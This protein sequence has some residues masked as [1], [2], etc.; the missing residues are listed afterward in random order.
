MFTD[1][2]RAL[3]HSLEAELPDAIALREILHA[4]PEPSHGEGATAGLVAEALGAKS[5]TRVAGTGLMA[6]AGP[7]GGR[8]VAV[9]AELDA[10][11]IKEATGAPFAATNGLMHACGHDVHMAALV[12]LF[13]AARRVE[14]RLPRPVLALYQPSEE[15][16]PSGAEVVAREGALADAAGGV[17]AV[18]VH[19][20]VPWGAVSVEAGPVN[21]SCDNLH[22]CIEGVGGHGAYP[23]L[24][25]D[26]IVAL[27]H[28]IVALQSLV[29]RR[30]D[31]MHAGVFS[32]GWTRAGTAENVIPGS[33]EAG[34]TLRVLQPGDREPLREAACDLI[35]ATARA[36]GCVATVE[37]TEGEP[38]TVNDPA[39][40]ERARSLLPEVGFDLAPPMRSCGS[41]DFGFYGRVAPALM[42]FVGLKDGPGIQN[43]PL[44]HPRFLPPNEAVG[45]VARAQAIALTAATT[46]R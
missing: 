15:A 9:R 6:R 12:A 14:D 38:P 30:L 2:F 39:L 46:T 33:A 25:R 10:L 19:P 27:S 21:A 7:G 13:R 23:H 28:A 17:V 22:I 32:V 11:P 40:A 45:A 5:V 16:Y 18:H 1:P 29:S 36:H 35:E 3:L 20:G 42:M 31:P 37:V 34:G 26:P 4:N 44:H 8:A 41:D 24:A 43:L